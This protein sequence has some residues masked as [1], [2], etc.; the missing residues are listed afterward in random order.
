MRYY[1]LDYGFPESGF[2][3]DQGFPHDSFSYMVDKDYVNSFYSLYYYHHYIWS[4][5]SKYCD[6]VLDVDVELL[7]N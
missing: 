1:N 7:Y 6:I 5:S 4:L 3:F 2:D